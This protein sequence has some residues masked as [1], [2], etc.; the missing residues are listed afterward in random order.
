MAKKQQAKK[1]DGKAETMQGVP[2]GGVQEQPA[3]IPPA[4]E[5]VEEPPPAKPPAQIRKERRGAKVAMAEEETVPSVL[6][7]D[8][9]ETSEVFEARIKAEK[10]AALEEEVAEVANGRELGT[11]V[12]QFETQAGGKAG[13]SLKF[14][15]ACKL[16]EIETGQ[17]CNF[18]RPVSAPVQKV[19][20]GT[21]QG[22][23]PMGVQPQAMKTKNCPGCNK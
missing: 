15:R 6:P 3:V 17:P 5:V 9:T 18:V 11:V 21:K 13:T 8:G 14:Y 10:I 16:N 2:S 22:F 4:I 20:Q 23:A 12:W 19:A 7:I 1:I